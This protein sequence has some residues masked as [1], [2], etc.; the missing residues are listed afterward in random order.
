MASALKGVD[1]VAMPSRWEACGLLAM[2]SL[3][4]GVPIVGSNCEGLGEVLEGSPAKRVPVGDVR[5]LVDALVEEITHLDRRTEA[6][7]GYQPE[8]VERFAIERPAR[9]LADLYTQLK[10][11][12][13]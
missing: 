11:R 7:R 8:A 1:L 5:A 10:T 4:A 9:A 2:E 3:S 6:F 12:A 13:N